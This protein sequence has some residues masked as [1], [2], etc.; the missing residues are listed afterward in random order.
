MKSHLWLMTAVI[1]TLS[2]SCGEPEHEGPFD[3]TVSMVSP[4]DLSF[5]NGQVM[6][7][8]SAT[9][10][11]ELVRIEF[12]VV[13]NDEE[14]LS[15]YTDAPLCEFVLDTTTLDDGAHRVVARAVFADGSMMEDEVSVVVDNSPPQLELVGPLPGQCVFAEDEL[16]HFVVRAFDLSLVEQMSMTVEGEVLPTVT[17]DVDDSFSGEIE[18]APYLEGT[19]TDDGPVELALEAVAVDALGQSSSVRTT[20]CIGSRLGWH[21]VVPVGEGGVAGLVASP[22]GDV[23]YVA[24]EIGGVYAL[25]AETGEEICHGDASAAMY[26]A[27]TLSPDG[28]AVYLGTQSGLRSGAAASCAPQ[29]TA[30]SGLLIQGRPAVDPTTGTIY[31]TNRSESGDGGLHA[32]NPSGSVL[33]NRQIPGLVRSGPTVIPSLGLAVVTS[34]NGNI[35]AV[36]L[37]DPSGDFV[38]VGETGGD[39]QSSATFANGTLYI[40]SSDFGVYAYDAASGDRVWDAPYL[41]DRNIQTSPAVDSEGYIYVTSQ[42]ARLYRLSPLKRLDWRYEEAIHVLYSNPVIAEGPELVFFGDTGMSGDDGIHGILHA[43]T[44][45]TGEAAWTATLDGSAVVSPAVAG[46]R[47]FVG[48]S[49]GQIYAFYLTPEAA[50]AAWSGSGGDDDP[51][52]EQPNCGDLGGTCQPRDCAA[53]TE[54][55]VDGGVCATDGESCCASRW[56]SVCRPYCS[57]EGTAAEGWYW[58]CDNSLIRIGECSGCDAMCVDASGLGLGEGWL[59]L[60]DRTVIAAADC[61]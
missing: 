9:P 59:N 49:S 7:T 45:S 47:V 48:T 51:E 12:S 16:A 35:Y 39:L 40:G 54:V 27:P 29:W 33:W 8:A 31:Y 36:S 43:V 10:L 2:S 50:F 32:A 37:A 3:V 46:T 11:D 58:S 15:R 18:L 26:R 42:D 56:T 52:P 38:W 1:V 13:H 24:T 20:L 60:C 30:S 14:V 41:T 23:V 34:D 57:F 44:M 28:S 22:A 6:V 17:R 25:N 55:V 21:S 61:P 4:E 19:G 53:D 5:I